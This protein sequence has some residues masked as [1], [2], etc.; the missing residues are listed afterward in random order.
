M[1]SW[2]PVCCCSPPA[3]RPAFFRQPQAG[4]SRRR[5]AP[6]PPSRSPPPR[7]E[8]RV[9]LTPAEWLWERGARHVG[10]GPGLL[11][12]DG[13]PLEELRPDSSNIEAAIID[14]A[15]GQAAPWDWRESGSVEMKGF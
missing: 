7:G 14:P 1:G 11:A 3:C 13:A 4:R 8:G 12:R 15:T 2:Q 6:P 5:R 9:D 10:G